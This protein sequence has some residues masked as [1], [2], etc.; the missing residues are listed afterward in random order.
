[1]MVLGVVAEWRPKVDRHQN[2]EIMW[3]EVGRLYP[4]PERRQTLVEGTFTLSN[5]RRGTSDMQYVGMKLGLLLQKHDVRDLQVTYTR[6]HSNVPWQELPDWYRDGAAPGLNIEFSP[7]DAV[8]EPEMKEIVTML[9]D[10]VGSS[11]GTIIDRGGYVGVESKNN[12]WG[13]SAQDFP[14]V[15]SINAWI[16]MLPCGGQRGLSRFF[17]D[18]DMLQSGY[19][20]LRLRLKS[21]PEGFLSL[22]FRLVTIIDKHEY[23]GHVWHRRSDSVNIQDLMN[24]LKD[25]KEASFE[26]CPISM[27]SIVLRREEYPP[28]VHGCRHYSPE[29]VICQMNNGI[30]QVDKNTGSDLEDSVGRIDVDVSNNLIWQTPL[31]SL[32][33]IQIKIQRGDAAVSDRLSFILFQMIPWEIPIRWETV[34]IFEEKRLIW[35]LREPYDTLHPAIIKIDDVIHTGGASR[36]NGSYMMIHG[37]ID[38]LNET[39]SSVTMHL[40]AVIERRLLSVFDYPPDMSRGIDI[41]APTFSLQRQNGN[42]QYENEHTH[43]YGRNILV[44]LPIPDASMPFNVTCFTATLIALIFGSVMNMALWSA[45]ELEAIKKQN[46]S[47][48][49]RF[50]R[51][52]LVLLVGGGSMVYLDPSTKA[53]VDEVLVKHAGIHVF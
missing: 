34:R 48:K 42:I 7:W 6:G 53:M 11:A 38:G 24:S 47:A 36:H 2:S 5:I 3:S 9:G 20:A 4:L 25:S 51:I 23:S 39:T 22:E 35:S 40:R 13:V 43:T 17:L 37:H 52:V 41:P 28:G 46:N 27:T 8:D 18:L 16:S 49:N 30:E 44:Q 1:M 45:Q 29:Y 21:S 31:L 14:C 50:I 10:A 19:H 32:L 33:N 12:F 15:E 26:E